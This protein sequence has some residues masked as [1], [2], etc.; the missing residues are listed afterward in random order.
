MSRLVLAIH[1][2]SSL[3]CLTDPP[4]SFFLPDFSLFSPR[5][6]SLDLTHT[7]GLFFHKVT[8]AHTVALSPSSGPTPFVSHDSRVV[9][10]VDVSL[11][12]LEQ[13]VVRRFRV[14]P[15]PHGVLE[16]AETVMD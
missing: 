14:L 2:I 10:G 3:L 8:H 12:R 4:H 11:Q 5:S 7:G 15:A 16:E 13:R 9:E 6:D 1:L